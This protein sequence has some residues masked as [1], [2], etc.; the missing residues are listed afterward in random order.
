MQPS[1]DVTVCITTF[2]QA[3]YIARCL[4]SV[5]AQLPPGRMEILVGDDGSRDDTRTIVSAFAAAYPGIV[6]PVFHANQLGP[7]GNYRA[8]VSAARGRYV[9]HLDGDDYWISGKIARQIEIL[10]RSPR[11]VAVVANALVVDADDKPLGFFTSDQRQSIAL[12]HLL[13]RGN[14]LCHGSLVYRAEYRHDI[15]EIPGNFVDYR[16][17]L[18]LAAKGSLEYLPEPLVV[19]RWNSAGSMRTTMSGL[20]GVNY[21]EAM[22]EGKSLGASP[23]AFRQGAV[24]FLEKVF[25]ACLLHG[26]VAEALEWMRRVRSQSPVTPNV[27]L[28][29]A[30]LRMPLALTRFVRRRCGAR[31]FRRVSVLYRR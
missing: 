25:A 19:Y 11:A 2:N 20:V 1:L 8:L 26:R 27:I 9:A 16:I 21:W 15:L 12:N 22:C 17:L 5:V 31:A 4:Q 18:R 3:A 13:A 7:S 10:E 24:R 14:F 30:L 29:L 6:V 23:A 28:A